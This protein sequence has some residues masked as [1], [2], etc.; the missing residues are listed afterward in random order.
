MT[1]LFIQK[2]TVNGEP[3]AK[4]GVDI[5]D[6]GMGFFDGA[7]ICEIVGLFLLEELKELDID[8][9]IYRDDGLA[10]CDLSPRG[11]ECTKKKMS[12]IFRK[13]NLEITIE[14]NRKRIEFLDVYLDLEKDEYGPFLKPNDTPVYVDAGSNHPPKVLE[15][16]PKG[17]NRRLST[18]SANKEI[19][20]KAAPTYQTALENSGHNF[21]L[22][23]E[24]VPEQNE[25]ENEKKTAKK[26]KRNIIWFNPPY[27]RA[28]M[29]NVGKTF[30]QTMDKHFPPGN[31]LHQIFNRSKVK[32][33]YRC[34]PN[35]ARKISGHNSKILNANK[36]DA[37]PARECNCRKKDECPVQ[38]KCLQ[39][40]VVYQ[41]TISRQDGRVDTYI[42]LSEP[43]FKDRFRNHKSNFKT[44]NPKNAT[45]L[46][47]HIWKLQD[48]NI[49]YDV[50]WKIV[51]RAKPFNHVTNYCQL[52]T[53]EKYFIIFQP[54]M[55]SI[56]SRNEIAGPCLHKHNK[57][58][59]KSKS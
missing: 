47:K 12:A 46:S 57:L 53:R 37:M 22:N 48:Q 18:I 33:S 28:V 34:T 39:D 50:S 24:Q 19:F 55:A 2:H 27:S 30:L 10:V 43:P 49:E 23:F 14:A 40:G 3:W 51:S 7:E 59:K 17:I 1:Y 16:I 56:N 58:L 9:G 8:V 29:T 36:T 25:N 45:S 44:R 4:K 26:R 41:A 35:L 11:V 42:G 52:C 6:V 32:M 5:F 13:H 20:D 21:K 31:P 15:N 38:G 54:E